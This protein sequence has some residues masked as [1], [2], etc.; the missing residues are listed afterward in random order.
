MTA[1]PMLD[2][3][4]MWLAPHIYLPLP[5]AL[6]SSPLHRVVKA[7][8]L[9]ALIARVRADERANLYT[10]GQLADRC[11]ESH[12]E[13]RKEGYARGLIEG[14]SGGR[15]E[16]YRIGYDT[17]WSLSAAEIERQTLDAV[18]DAILRLHKP[19]A[20]A[21]MDTEVLA[22]IDAPRVPMSESLGHDAP[23][24]DPCDCHFCRKSVQS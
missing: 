12:E 10:M 5:S 2:G 20:R 4:S 21:Y 18:E 3:I 6:A 19:W 8:D 1:D 9:P 7:S 17:A 22:A 13:G 14:D 16:G 24:D 15:R 11:E 23:H